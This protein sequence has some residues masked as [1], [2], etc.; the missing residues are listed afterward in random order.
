[1]GLIQSSGCAPMVEAFNRQQ[2]VATPVEESTTIIAT[3]ATGTPGRAYEIL[4]DYVDEYGGHFISASDEEAFQ[5]IRVLAQQDGMS[6]EPATGVTFAG[7]FKMVREGII[8]P[9]DVVVVNVSGHTL[10]VETR[11]L[12]EQWQKLIDLSETPTSRQKCPKPA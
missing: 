12:G 8:Q 3:L 6:V 2:R 7:L 5:A 1:M 9:D 11:I 10:P 4:Y